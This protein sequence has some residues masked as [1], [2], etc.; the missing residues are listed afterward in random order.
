MQPVPGPKAKGQGD[1]RPFTNLPQTLNT[2]IRREKRLLVKSLIF[3]Y[4]GDDESIPFFHNNKIRTRAKSCI[5][6][7]DFQ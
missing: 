2:K 3:S 6:P 7:D 4:N 1:S 5:W